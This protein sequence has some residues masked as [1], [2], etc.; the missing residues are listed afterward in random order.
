VASRPDQFLL[1]MSN[2][3]RGDANSRLFS[4]SELNVSILRNRFSEVSGLNSLSHKKDD[5][6]KSTMHPHGARSLD[7]C[8]PVVSVYDNV[9][10]QRSCSNFTMVIQWCYSGDTVVFQWCYSVVTLVLQ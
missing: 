9:V 3:S 6:L 10:S 8:V 2:H 5:N 1:H 4:F 7:S